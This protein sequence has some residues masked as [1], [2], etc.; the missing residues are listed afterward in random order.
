MHRMFRPAHLRPFGRGGH[1]S[2]MSVKMQHAKGTF[3]GGN[4]SEGYAR[5]EALP[6]VAAAELM[7]GL[8]P[9]IVERVRDFRLEE[10]CGQGIAYVGQAKR[11]PFQ[12]A[13]EC[14]VLNIA[15]L[16]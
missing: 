3:F 1:S 13:A 5:D 7:H 6:H 15:T 16:F 4:N 11:S 10:D 8:Q 2:D 14:H 12:I 9:L